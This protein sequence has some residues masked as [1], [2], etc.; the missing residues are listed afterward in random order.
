MNYSGSAGYGRAYTKRLEGQYGI[1]DLQDCITAPRALASAP[2]LLIDPKRTVIR[3]R[4]SGG[5][6]VLNAISGGPPGALD[7]DPESFAFA[8]AAS[9]SHCGISELGKM[10]EDTHKFESQY[11]RKLMGG[12]NAQI[13]DVYRERSPLYRAERIATPLLV[14]N[15][16]LGTLFGTLVLILV[17]RSYYRA[18][19]TKLCQR[20]SR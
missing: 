6:V 5:Y 1:R 12:T 20:T 4:S 2:H 16:F 7:S 15:S 10:E 8:F 19:K 14:C 9:M 13:P 18:V 3:G 17:L 11:F